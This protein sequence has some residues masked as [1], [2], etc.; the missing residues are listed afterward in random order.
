[1]NPKLCLIK[2]NDTSAMLE[3]VT[4]IDGPD[5]DGFVTTDRPLPSSSGLTDRWHISRVYTFDKDLLRK[6]NEIAYPAVDL[7]TSALQILQN[8]GRLEFSEAEAQQRFL[9]EHDFKTRH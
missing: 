8:E 2:Y 4:V 5:K 6:V 3:P 1:M 7:A 9:E